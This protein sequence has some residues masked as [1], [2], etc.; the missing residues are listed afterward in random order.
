M[1]SE[2]VALR[3][4]PRFIEILDRQCVKLGGPVPLSRS[5]AIRELLRR[6]DAEETAER[7][8]QKRRKA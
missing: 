6:A 8:Q 4:E 7:Q 3:L 1:P 5:D 2:R